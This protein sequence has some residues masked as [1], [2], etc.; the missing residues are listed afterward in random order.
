M[1]IDIKEVN[2]IVIADIISDEILIH[3]TQDALNLMAECSE[4]GARHIILH[5]N[6]ITPEFFDLKT[7]LAGEILQKF[8]NYQVKLTVAGDFTRIKSKAFQ[9]FVRESNT[10]GQIHFVSDK[11]PG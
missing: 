3:N 10:Q 9:D 7:G 5:E 1:N 2:N 6:H 11:A 8:V 4:L